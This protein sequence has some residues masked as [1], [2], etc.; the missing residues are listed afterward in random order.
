MN[1]GGMMII[2]IIMMPM[3]ALMEAA[4]AGKLHRNIVGVVMARSH[5]N[6]VAQ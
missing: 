2:T 1:V 3:M 4:R 6:L 5:E